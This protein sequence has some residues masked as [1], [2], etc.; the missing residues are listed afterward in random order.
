MKSA[1]NGLALSMGSDCIRQ[2][3]EVRAK[4]IVTSCP[5]CVW[6]LRESAEN[7]A[8]AVKIVDLVTFVNRVL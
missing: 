2:A 5:T 3:E 7:A 4:M 6:N 1:Y 8:S